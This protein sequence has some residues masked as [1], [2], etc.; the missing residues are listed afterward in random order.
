MF[1]RI[2]HV[3]VLPSD[4]ERTI[5]FYQEVLGFTLAGRFPVDTPLLKEIVYLKLADTMVE[6]LAARA[7]TSAK[8]DPSQVGYHLLALEV[9]NMEQAIAYLA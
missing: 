6:V 9:E 4:P 1:K 8:M 2:D 7:P 3:E 5:A